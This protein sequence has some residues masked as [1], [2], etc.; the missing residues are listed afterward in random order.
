VDGKELQ[1]LKDLLGKQHIT[2]PVMVDSRAPDGKAWGK[3]SASYR[4]FAE[5]SEVWIDTNGYVVRHD[6]ADRALVQENDWWMR[7]LTENA[8]SKDR[9]D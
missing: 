3:T 5:P 4:V 7:S 8:K 9:D 1:E 6:D 2:F